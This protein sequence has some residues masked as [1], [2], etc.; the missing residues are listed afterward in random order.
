VHCLTLEFLILFERFVREYVTVVRVFF[1]T[2]VTV[3]AA[4]I[5]VVKTNGFS[6][7]EGSWVRIYAYLHYMG[8]PG[9]NYGGPKTGRT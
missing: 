1:K 5:S 2:N 6:T 7:L 9:L 4:A 8:G 3:S